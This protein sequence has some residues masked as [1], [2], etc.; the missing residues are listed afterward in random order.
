MKMKK[1]LACA[2]STLIL[3]GCA[4]FASCR[5]EN[6]ATTLYIEMED[7]GWGTA[8]IQ[9]L[10]EIFEAEHEGITVKVS[11]IVKG[12]GEIRDKVVS[13]SSYL[14]LI[15]IEYQFEDIMTPVRTPDG[16][17]YDY[18]F[19]DLSD[20]FEEKVPGENILLKDKMILADYWESTINDGAAAGKQYSFPWMASLESIVVNKDVIP[21]GMEDLPRTTDDFVEYCQIAQ[22]RGVTPIVHSLDTSYWNNLYSLWMFQYY[23]SHATQQFYQGYDMEA[24]DDEELRFQPQIYANDG[25]LYALEILEEILSPETGIN[26]VQAQSLDFTAV[27]NRFLNTEN[28]VLFMPNGLWLER[29]ME[30]N[31]SDTELNIEFMRLP[32]NSALGEKLG[33]ENKELSAIIKWIDEGEIPEEEPVFE[34]TVCSKEDV[35]DAV[36][37]ARSLITANFGFNS[38]IPS[39]ST[40]IDLAKEFLQLMA[41]DRG[42]EA[43]YSTCGGAA[44]FQYPVEKLESLYNDGKISRFAY[45]GNKMIQESVYAYGDRCALFTKNN[46]GVNLS[47]TKPASA[48]A[49]PD[50]EDRLR[51][52]DIWE[53]NRDTALDSWDRFLRTAGIEL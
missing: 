3:F 12:S 5:Q 46:I 42:L 37:D 30:G 29:E 40:K 45:L 36:R 34:S 24:P 51:P 53:D 4:S 21:S 8:W 14:D 44:G 38:L 18:P 48:F 19:A 16:T 7:A 2:L 1:A 35:I 32:V 27:Q 20:I 47:S 28:N 22:N 33:I 25:L 23:G 13:G 41:T 26:D 11:T 10:I 6:S 43:M 9:P 17:R 39:Y 15:F 31:W 50:A 52:I 49:A